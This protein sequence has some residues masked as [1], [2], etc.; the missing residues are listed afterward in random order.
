[1]DG[2]D[3]IFIIHINF[4]LIRFLFFTQGLKLD[5]FE[6]AYRSKYGKSI[7]VKTYGYETIRDLLSRMKETIIV[8]QHSDYTFI[9]S[10][11]NMPL[12]PVTTNGTTSHCPKSQAKSEAVMKPKQNVITTNNKSHGVPDEIKAEM[13]EMISKYE[14]G[15]VA[16]SFFSIIR[17]NNN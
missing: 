4:T 5:E 8:R 12:E 9:V 16:H 15:I 1:M 3:C 17:V 13:K 7:N 10:P 11:R 2:F 14:Q 6:S